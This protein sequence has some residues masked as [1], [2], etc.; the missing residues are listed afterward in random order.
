[1][2]VRPLAWEPPYA[3]DAALKKK[4][5]KRKKERRAEK[6]E[7]KEGGKE[8]EGEGERNQ[9]RKT[10]SP[11]KIVAL[12]LVAERYSEYMDSNWHLHILLHSLQQSNCN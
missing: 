4:K 11:G 2:P 6:E 3:L 12:V 5:K 9:R 8:G 7:G 10:R 1:M